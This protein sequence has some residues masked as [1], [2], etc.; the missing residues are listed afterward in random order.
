MTKIIY[1][2]FG[3]ANLKKKSLACLFQAINL[4]P[5][6][7]VHARVVVIRIKR[8]SLT[9]NRLIVLY[10]GEKLLDCRG[11]PG[12]LVLY[13]TTVIGFVRQAVDPACV[14][15]Y[16]KPERQSFNDFYFKARA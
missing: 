15:D 1:G 5:L 9:A 10:I 16:W 6:A 8:F 13:Y 14:S 11:K 4:I 7:V 3:C 12:R 2:R